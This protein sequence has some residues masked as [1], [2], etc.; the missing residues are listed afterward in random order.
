MNAF[1]RYA[2]HYCRGTFASAF[3]A[4]N[5]ALKAVLG[6][7]GAAVA[8][9]ATVSMPTGKEALAIWAG[10][11]VIGAVN[12]FVSNPIPIPQLPIPAIIPIP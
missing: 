5:V 2:V 9:P 3:N 4:G 10:A 11:A 1:Q 12:Y 8:L 7:A 6:H